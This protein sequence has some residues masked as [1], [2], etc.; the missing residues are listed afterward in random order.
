MEQKSIEMDVEQTSPS[1]RE[2]GSWDRDKCFLRSHD[3]LKPNADIT[4]GCRVLVLSG[5]DVCDTYEQNGEMITAMSDEE[6]RKEDAYKK[7]KNKA[8]LLQTCFIE[9][10]MKFE[11][12]DM[13]QYFRDF[14]NMDQEDLA[15]S[16]NNII[17][18]IRN[19]MPTYIVLPFQAVRFSEPTQKRDIIQTMID[20]DARDVLR[21]KNTEWDGLNGLVASDI[22]KE[23]RA[24][25]LWGKP[26][27]ANC[28]YVILET[29][30]VAHTEKALLISDTTKIS[31]DITESLPKFLNH[32]ESSKNEEGQSWHQDEYFFKGHEELLSEHNAID[33]PRCQVLVLSGTYLY[34]TYEQN[35]KMITVMNDAQLR[36]NDDYK[37]DKNQTELLQNKLAE[38]RFRFTVM[39]MSKYFRNMSDMNQWNPKY[40]YI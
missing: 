20:S 21:K 25:G 9:S 31:S 34:D 30:K 13:G 35:G 3:A 40:S 7:D 29:L 26:V 8:D 14:E 22:I 6:L 18:D 39:D 36:N 28:N 27:V 37:I 12:V 1:S 15:R 19:F 4:P 33:L 5:T 16:K 17:G 38:S 2:A 23:I 32:V 10:D 24:S 11:V